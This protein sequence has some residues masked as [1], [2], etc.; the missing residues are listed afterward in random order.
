MDGSE[1][2][3]K[4]KVAIPRAASVL[5]EEVERAVAKTRRLAAWK[6]RA[7]E[8]PIPPGEQLDVRLVSHLSM[9]TY[10]P[11]RRKCRR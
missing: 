7:R 1:S 6:A 3:V 9:R 4:G 8:W 2:T 5:S 11:A 10:R